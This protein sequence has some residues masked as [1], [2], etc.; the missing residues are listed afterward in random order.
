MTELLILLVFAGFVA[1][2]IGT[3]GFRL[4]AGDNIFAAA[5][6]SLFVGVGIAGFVALCI[7][8]FFGFDYLF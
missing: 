4:F 3:I 2:V 7:A 1:G 5:I 8:A 6:W